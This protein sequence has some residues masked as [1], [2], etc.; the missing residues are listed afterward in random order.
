MHIERI[1]VEEGYLAGLDLQFSEGLNVL[2]GPRG[3]GKTSII[4][5]L[6]F[7]LGVRAYS[8]E[9]QAAAQR[10]ALGVLGSGR[11]TVL[12]RVGAD[13]QAVVRTAESAEPQYPA[14]G[15]PIILSQ[16]QVELL[17]LDPRQRLRLLDEHVHPPLHPDSERSL[18]ASVISHTAELRTLVAELTSLVASRE[19][20]QTAPPL[21]AA[22]LA[23]QKRS[24]VGTEA[25]ALQKQLDALTPSATQNS[26]ADSVLKRAAAAF[27][28]AKGAIETAHAAL[29]P[30]ES[31]PAAAGAKDLLGPQRQSYAEAVELLAKAAQLLAHC[32]QANTAAI[33]QLSGVRE[34]TEQKFRE[35]RTKL[36]ALKSGAGEAAKRVGQL[37]QQVAQL[38]TLDTTIAARRKSAEAVREKRSAALEKLD[39]LRLDVF[40]ARRAAAGV[41]SARLAPTITV[42]VTHLANRS[43]YV[44]ALATALRGSGLQYTRLANQLAA[45]SP[46]EL[47]SAAETSDFT[48]LVDVAGIQPDRAQRTLLALREA[49]LGTL[50]T[51]RI[52]DDV[53]LQL[54]DGSEPKQIEQLST[55]QRCTLVLPIILMHPTRTI[56]ADQPEDHLDNAFVVQ[57]LVQAIRSRTESGQMIIAT[58]NPNIPVLGD[59]R[60]V[61]LL[62]SDG[63]R[64]FVRQSLP[65]SDRRTVDAISSLMEGGRE[66]FRLRSE[67][68]SKK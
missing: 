8:E 56:V 66:A 31:W 39:Q 23:E 42:G 38:S 10:H 48:P 5:L 60:M 32:V 15:R 22:A 33:H 6:R 17:G 62:G 34:R 53:E 49:D 47:I 50:L 41:L 67:Y 68:Y 20:L 40:E 61:T 37:Q 16:N 59:A 28:S 4:E 52:D 45:L 30:V 7:A 3:V 54:L 55:G 9:A 29:R 18:V 24:T 36:E 26:V 46:A 63:R 51:L 44:E 64:G 14:T 13:V 35:V 43:A 11:V 58:H 1:T 25:L 57:T 21:L 19:A 27:E 65:L 12:V 2:I